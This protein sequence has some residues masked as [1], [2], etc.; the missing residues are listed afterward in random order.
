MDYLSVKNNHNRSRSPSPGLIRSPNPTKDR[1]I[2]DRS[3]LDLENSY[4]LLDQKVLQEDKKTTLTPARI[5]KLKCE[6]F[7]EEYVCQNSFETNVINVSGKENVDSRRFQTKL[8]GLKKI[9]RACLPF[10]HS[11]TLLLDAP[12]VSNDFCMVI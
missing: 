9:E 10:N 11:P 7:I 3:Q 5:N 2:P 4:H 1:F 6:L 12:A 8:A